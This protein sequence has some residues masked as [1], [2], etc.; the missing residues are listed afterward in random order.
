MSKIIVE[1]FVLHRAGTLLALLVFAC[2]ARADL[3]TSE[4]YLA[5]HLALAQECPK[6]FPDQAVAIQ[7]GA[8]VMVCDMT[9]GTTELREMYARY[10]A[11]V[12]FAQRIKDFESELRR[13]SLDVVQQVCGELAI[14]P[15]PGR[16]CELSPGSDIT[17]NSR[18]VH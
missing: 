4:D 9:D 1:L 18:S 16:F 5:Q 13:S 10:Q 2:S 6:L 17:A 12:K 3:P 7:R 15:N 14:Y 11:K 8:A